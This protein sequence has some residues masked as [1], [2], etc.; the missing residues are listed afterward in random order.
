LNEYLFFAQPTQPHHDTSPH[1]RPWAKCP[2]M[3]AIHKRIEKNATQR[4]RRYVD[5]DPTKGVRADAKGATK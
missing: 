4:R 5:G 3:I 2:G 1:G